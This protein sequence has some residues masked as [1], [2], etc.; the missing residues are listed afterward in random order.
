MECMLHALEHDA[1]LELHATT[2]LIAISN[3]MNLGTIFAKGHRPVY[4]SMRLTAAAIALP[5]MQSRNSILWWSRW[6]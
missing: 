5:L 4:R 1:A 2:S 3:R 6:P